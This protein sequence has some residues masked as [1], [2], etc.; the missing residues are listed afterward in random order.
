MAASG[1]QSSME[2][3][4]DDEMIRALLRDPGIRT[5]GRGDADDSRPYRRFKHPRPC[6]PS[7]GD[8]TLKTL[9]KTHHIFDGAGRSGREPGPYAQHG[10]P[11]LPGYRSSSWKLQQHQF[12]PIPS[13]FL[14]DQVAAL[15]RYDP[16]VRSGA[17]DASRAMTTAAHRVDSALGNHR[18]LFN[19]T[20][21]K[22]LRAE[23]AWLTEA[24][25]PLSHSTPAQEQARPNVQEPWP[26]ETAQA[27]G[28]RGTAPETAY[29]AAYNTALIAL[30][31]DRYYRLIADL[32]LFCSAP[33]VRKARRRSP[34][35]NGRPG[36]VPT[37]G[38]DAGPRAT[39]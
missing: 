18:R 29:V 34:G 7:A 20:A 4:R 38:V 30:E 2:G 23:L 26:N 13:S 12:E 6:S 15:L 32:Q 11:Q 24:M 8:V 33:P 17:Q 19:K 22:E 37:W 27:Y 36:V 35:S 39:M 16:A 3:V 31:S 1:P 10:S 28:R 25:T 14:F 9:E 21:V 5:S